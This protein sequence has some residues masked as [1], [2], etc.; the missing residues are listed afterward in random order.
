MRAILGIGNIGKR[1]AR[2]RHN[3]GFMFLDYMVDKYSLQFIPSKSDYYYCLG[4]FNGADF[5]LIRPSTYVNNSGIAAEHFISTNGI[6]SDELLVIHDDLN[7]NFGVIKTKL[8]GG[9][10]GHNGLSSIIYNLNSDS[11]PRIRIGIG[12]SFEKGSQVDY[13]LED[14]SSDE[15]PVLNSLFE[16][17]LI[18]TEEFIANGSK[19]MLDA[20][21]RLNPKEKKKENGENN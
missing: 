15:M 8:N 9:D 5:A 7:L 17:T 4:I 10:G 3:V 20:N 16:K 19:G 1:Y 18:L 13:V 2:T 12:A 6:S 11:F 14:F 21:S